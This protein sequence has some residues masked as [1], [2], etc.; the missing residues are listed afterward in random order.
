MSNTYSIKLESLFVK[1]K[2]G[3]NQETIEEYNKIALGKIVNNAEQFYLGKSK[4]VKL[5]VLLNDENSLV[6]SQTFT[7]GARIF[8]INKQ[9]KLIII[10]ESSILLYN[11][12]SLLAGDL[13]DTTFVYYGQFSID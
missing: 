5:H 10:T 2:D 3:F 11:K 4:K 12:E 13:S 6:L 7:G 1:S 8:N 9:L